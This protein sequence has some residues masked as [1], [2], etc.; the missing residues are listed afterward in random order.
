MLL[1]DSVE[2]WVPLAATDLSS[3]I[4]E[5]T[6]IPLC[7]AS[8]RQLLA[9]YAQIAQQLAE[10]PDDECLEQS[11][12]DEPASQPDPSTNQRVRTVT[13]GSDLGA[14]EPRPTPQVVSDSRTRVP[15]PELSADAASKGDTT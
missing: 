15:A 9:T 8:V 11:P 4:P 2:R 1:R 12:D 5:R 14:V 6:V 3:H 13:A 10:E 7:L